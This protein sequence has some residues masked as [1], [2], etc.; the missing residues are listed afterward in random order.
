MPNTMKN[1]PASGMPM[2]V[3]KKKSG[4]WRMLTDLRITNKMI[5]PISCLQ[6]GNLLLSLLPKI[7]SMIV[8]DLKD[9]FSTFPF[10][11]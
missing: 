8:V 7:R 5:Q 6:S 10:R 2:L 3:I 9:S 11:V 1:L 4:K